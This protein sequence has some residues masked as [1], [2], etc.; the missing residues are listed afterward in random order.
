MCVFFA[1]SW[2]VEREG[3]GDGGLPPRPE[4]RTW[5]VRTS[6]ALHR[7]ERPDTR[8]LA[9]QRPLWC[10]R[11][12]GGSVAPRNPCARPRRPPDQLALCRFT[13]AVLGAA[14]GIGQPLSLLL[15]QNPNVAE[16]R[17]SSAAPPCPC[18]PLRAAA[19]VTLCPPAP[20]STTWSTRPAWRRTCL[21]W[22][23]ACGCGPSSSRSRSQTPSGGATWWS[24][25]LGC[26]ASPA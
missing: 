18:A 2:S 8:F 16:L 25:R 20:G 24:S 15:M 13:V 12:G 23:R 21:T 6:R 17:C 22:T 9:C 7:C 4:V 14:G 1:G 11:S 5:P 26:P 19:P 10:C 3:A